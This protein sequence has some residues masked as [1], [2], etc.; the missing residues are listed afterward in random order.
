MSRRD[1]HH[2]RN[3]RLPELSP[4]TLGRSLVAILVVLCT[5]GL[6]AEVAYLYV[7]IP[8]ELAAFF[9][10]SAETNLPTWVASCLLF[11]CAVVLFVIARDA[12]RHVW[13]WRVLAILFA[14]ISLDEAVEIHEHLGGLVD[15]SGALYFSWVIPASVI[16]FVIGV[17]YVPFVTHLDRQVRRRFVLA[18][19]IYVGGALVMELPLGWWTEQHGDDNLGYALMDW[20][21]ETMELA[22]ASYFLVSLWRYRSERS[23]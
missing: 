15:A 1:D 20:V 22:G 11:S 23:Q 18:G 9:S 7:G 6:A 21:E 4:R 12:E 2:L 5:A 14:Y 17:V 10:L 8:G 19:V 3:D 13:H 16:V